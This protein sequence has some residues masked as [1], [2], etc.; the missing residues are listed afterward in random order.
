[1]PEPL[2]ALWALF[3]QRCPRCHKGKMF[4]GIFAMNDPCPT[5]GTLFQREEGYFL[6]AMYFSCALATAVLMP[7]YLLAMLLLPG[8]STLVVALAATA[9]Y[10]PFVPAVFRYSRLLWVYVDY[11]VSP[12]ASCAAP[13]EKVRREQL[14]RR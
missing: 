12:G 7:L 11:L 14:G 8:Q 6:G 13:Y 9:C 10:V 1:M 2:D 3:W 4:R 5:C